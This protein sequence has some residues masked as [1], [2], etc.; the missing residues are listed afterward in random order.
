[1][2]QAEEIPMNHRIIGVIITVVLFVMHPALA[3]DGEQV[4]RSA[5]AWGE[6]MLTPL[7]SIEPTISRQSAVEASSMSAP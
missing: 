6:E 2:T 7:E 5:L 3:Q 4:E 1:M